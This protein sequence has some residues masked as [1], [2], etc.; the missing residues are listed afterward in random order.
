M[1]L[2]S[3]SALIRPL[4]VNICEESE[5]KQGAS[6]ISLSTYIDYIGVNMFSI[7]NEALGDFTPTPVLEITFLRIKLQ[8]I[9]ALLQ[10]N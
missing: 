9:R 7:H 1:N 5:R 10:V 4:A 6:L 2:K 3:I 8:V